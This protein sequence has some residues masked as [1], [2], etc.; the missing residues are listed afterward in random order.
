VGCFKNMVQQT[1]CTVALAASAVSLLLPANAQQQ[2][3]VAQVA[4]YSSAPEPVQCTAAVGFECRFNDS[5]SQMPQ[6]EVPAP[7]PP[8]KSKHAK[9][10]RVL[11]AQSARSKI[12]ERKYNQ[13]LQTALEDWD[14]PAAEAMQA[15]DIAAADVETPLENSIDEALVQAELE[16]DAALDAP[17]PT[18]DWRVEGTQPDVDA[19]LGFEYP[20]WSLPLEIVGSFEKND[21]SAIHT[22][23]KSI[24]KQVAEI[25]SQESKQLVLAKKENARKQELRK[26]ARVAAAT[27]IAAKR[28]EPKN[29]AP[30]IMPPSVPTPSVP[31]LSQQQAAVEP[32]VAVA[33]QAPVGNPVQNPVGTAVKPKLASADF[34]SGV[35]EAWMHRMSELA[36]DEAP[37]A[38]VSE[39]TLESAMPS[40]ALP[41]LSAPT[42]PNAPAEPGQTGPLL[43]VPSIQAPTAASQPQMAQQKAAKTT[44]STQTTQA[45]SVTELKTPEIFAAKQPSVSTPSSVYMASHREVSKSPFGT[46]LE[47]RVTVDQEVEDFLAS[48]KASLE[49]FLIPA[50][51]TDQAD[52]IFLLRYPDQIFRMDA[53]K[54]TG[55]FQVVA[56]AFT[57]ELSDPI[58]RAVYQQT[59]T[60]E[61]ARQNIRFHISLAALLSGVVA[62]DPARRSVSVSLSVFEGASPNHREPNPIAGARVQ[63]AGLPEWGEFFTDQ[64]GD[65]MNLPAFPVHSR[66]IF[67]VSAGDRYLPTMKAVS[68][69]ARDP[70][71]RVFL[72]ERSKANW[73]SLL[74]PRTQDGKP[75]QAD[76]RS[77]VIMGRV[78][79]LQAHLPREGD[80]VELRNH[81]SEKL[82]YFG[83]GSTEPVTRSEGFFSFFQVPKGLHFIDR[84]ASEKGNRALA[85][86]TRGGFG[87]YVEFGKMGAHALHG[88]VDDFST[89]RRLDSVEY[90]LLGD[91]A[92]YSAAAD[93]KFA[94]PGIEF[95]SGKLTVEF[96]RAGYPVT[97]HTAPFS[98]LDRQWPRKYSMV[99]QSDIEAALYQPGRPKWHY[100]TGMV[101]G[102]ARGSLFDMAQDSAVEVEL[103]TPSGKKV[104][105]SNGPFPLYGSEPSL[106][107]TREKPGFAF[108]NLVPGEY[109]VLWRRIS[110]R[111]I[112]RVDVTDVGPRIEPGVVN[113]DHVSVV[114]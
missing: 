76:S 60:T 13:A 41:A 69:G 65:V 15:A 14:A 59:V 23:L 94:L 12:D 86:R 81:D 112:I 100:S 106:G 73:I 66:V 36:R 64:H 11:V 1:L 98:P 88:V 42:A 48:R 33:V 77:A 30:Q 97:W 67:I 5:M 80:K 39:S 56:L 61:N 50:S 85:L 114:D 52:P 70:G 9:R 3:V 58:G 26:K 74:L 75:V 4:Q 40:P 101:L 110:D 78:L 27:T 83:P 62:Q 2:I 99:S 71:E 53:E 105:S 103:R 31:V 47:G 79:D 92:V 95:P 44:V 82:S 6:W 46:R 102:K 8:K 108:W 109:V 18:V 21:F 45:V 34:V 84:P 24:R 35:S 22:R 89:H 91:N 57:P 90:K 55:E 104:S 111:Q 38:L 87:Y 43:V 28:S 51:R 29:A 7:T 49:L 25:Q 10:V 68:I 19:A 107:L 37:P 54:L 96:R 63:V 32:A 20:R 17:S 16:K 113:Q 72:I 93:G